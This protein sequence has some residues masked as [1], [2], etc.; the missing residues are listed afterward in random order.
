MAQYVST[1][2]NGGYRLQ[3]K[4]VREIEQPSLNQDE[5]GPILE[6]FQPTVLNRIDM[7]P[8]YIKQVQEGFRQVMHG[9]RYGTSYLR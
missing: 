8:A 9:G 1:I 2:A 4:I 5:I 7:K 6:P 3:P